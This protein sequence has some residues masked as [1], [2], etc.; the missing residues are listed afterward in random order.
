M[1]TMK[2]FRILALGLAAALLTSVVVAEETA[3]VKSGPQVGEE[4]AGPFH[5]LNINGK[6]AGKKHC[7]YC[8]MARTRSRWSSPVR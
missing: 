2:T 6:A 4:L 3:K 7:L 1:D 5:P 8:E